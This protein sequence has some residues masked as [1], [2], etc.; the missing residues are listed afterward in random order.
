[1][2]EDYCRTGMY[3]KCERYNPH[4][5]FTDVLVAAEMTPN[6]W[7]EDAKKTIGDGKDDK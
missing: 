2:I 4:E 5:F 7:I 6:L 3:E 1:M